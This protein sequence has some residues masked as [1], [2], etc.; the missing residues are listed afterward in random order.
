M[1]LQKAYWKQLILADIPVLWIYQPAFLSKHYC[2]KYRRIISL[3]PFNFPKNNLNL[4]SHGRALCGKISF[5]VLKQKLNNSQRLRISGSFSK[6]CHYLIFCTHFSLEIPEYYCC[7][8]L[9]VHCKRKGHMV[10]IITFL[11]QL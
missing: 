11:C 3:E 1:S 6:M 2:E 8:F 5:K 10:L 9:L 7:V 4:A